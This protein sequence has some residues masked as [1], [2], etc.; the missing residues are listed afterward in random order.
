MRGLYETIFGT[1]GQSQTELMDTRAQGLANQA[2]NSA[3]S[4]YAQQASMANAQQSQ[5]AAQ[6]YT[7]LLQGHYYKN[8]CRWMYNGQECTL[9]EFTELMFPDDEQ[10]RLMFILKHGGV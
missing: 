4:Q 8:Q 9:K 2:F 7:A 10:A 5:L 3:Y 6:Q 1:C